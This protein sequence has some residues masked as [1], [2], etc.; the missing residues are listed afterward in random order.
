V[1]IVLFLKIPNSNSN[2]VHTVI[3]D[4]VRNVVTNFASVTVGKTTDVVCK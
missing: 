3:H 2:V 1:V 4:V